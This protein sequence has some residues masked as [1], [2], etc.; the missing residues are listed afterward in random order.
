MKELTKNRA[1]LLKLFYAHPEQAFYM[2][3]IGRILRKKPGVFQ[4]TL[5]TM[6]KQGI[7]K[8]EFKANARYFRA[9]KEYSIYKELRSIISKIGLAL[10]LLLFYSLPGGICEEAKQAGMPLSLAEAIKV[11][12]KNNKDIQ[13][14]EREVEAARADIVGARS[15]FLPKV[16]LNAGYT[17]N[18]AVLKS[19]TPAK[20]DYGVFAGYE[21]EN[22]IGV[23]LDESLYNGGANIAILKQARLQLTAQEE[24][25]RAKKLDTE[26]EA[27][28]LYYG[29]LLAYETER[30]AHDLVEQAK[31]H[32]QDV[33]DRFGQ[34]TSSRFD[35][36]QSKVQVSK[37]IPQFI[38]AKN[39]IN[40]VMA[41]LNKLLGFKVDN[42]IEPKEKLEHSPIEIKEGEFLRQA[43]LGKP[44]MII[45]SLGVDINKWAIKE[46]NAT[47][48]PQIDIN[49]AYNYKSNNLK[50]MFMPK[51]NNWDLGVAVTI[52]IFDGFSTKAKVDAARERYAQAILSKDNLS[53]QIAVDIRQA[54][55]DLGEAQAVI[56]SQKDN[57]EEAREALRIA[58]IS[59][60]NGVAK[61]L[62]LLDAQVSLAQIEQN[63]AA[64]IYDYI[65]ARAQLDRTMG[66]EFLKEAENENTESK[67]K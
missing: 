35:L 65:M 4:R 43:Y 2:Q 39:D 38:K 18:A 40:L 1:R 7:L 3:E 37:L 5:Y 6:E 53:D 64:G 9:N 15:N 45:K 11:A 27:R 14:Q 62:D 12:Y 16:N 13:I 29:L 54:C 20:K 34:G 44:E 50:S 23:S 63:L 60:D 57:V 61:N 42:F 8:S 47:D 58:E 25:L 19:T 30:I 32:Y 52:P 46:A 41:D 21:N 48:R 33:K 17:H 67:N 66:S 28:R 59:Y 49:G 51:H 55:L 56:D 31:A 22:R 36:L 24:S 26:F 10:I